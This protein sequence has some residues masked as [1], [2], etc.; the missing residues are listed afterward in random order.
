MLLPFLAAAQIT[1]K[2]CFIGN[3]Y[4][5]SN[6]LPGLISNLATADGNTLVKDQNTPGGYTLQLHSTNATS[7]A[8]IQGNNWDYVVLQD[9]SQIPSFPWSQVQT[10]VFPFA[11]SLCESIRAANSCAIPLFFDTWGRQNGDPQW[12]SIDTFTEMNQ[13]LYNAYEYMADENS[14]LLAPVGIA[15]EHIA[16]D[17]AGDVSFAQLYSGDGSHPSVFGSYLAACIFYEQIF[18][19]SSLGNSF[20]PSGVNTTQA[21]Y[22]QN[23]AHHVL[24]N[25]D[26]I[27]TSFIQPVA[28]F[29]TVLNGLDVSFV[30]ASEHSFEWVWNFGDG[31]SATASD[32][33]HTYSDAGI[34]TVSLIAIY[35]DRSDTIE[36]TIDMAS[37]FMQEFGTDFLMYPNPS[38]DGMVKI[39]NYPV[40]DKKIEIYSSDGKWIKSVTLNSEHIQLSLPAGTYLIKT[41]TSSQVLLVL[42]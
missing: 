33:T 25:V 41:E 3:S 17:G 19:T 30:N 42:E 28:E 15:F 37:A 23:V 2:V 20:L 39:S 4:T 5:Y 40:S 12:D 21:G 10:D 24:T 6:D 11:E 27:A 38:C 9:Q 1:K 31:N 36:Y 18:E 35:C 32:P 14:G 26:S 34:Y 8:K 16:N 13:R 29:S 22:L 7:L